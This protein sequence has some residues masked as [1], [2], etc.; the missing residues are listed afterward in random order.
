MRPSSEPITFVVLYNTATLNSLTPLYLFL[1]FITTSTQPVELLF[2]VILSHTNT[3]WSKRWRTNP[4]TAASFKI[5]R[6]TQECCLSDN[7]AGCHAIISRLGIGNK[8]MF[9]W[10]RRLRTRRVWWWGSGQWSWSSSS[11]K[12]ASAPGWKSRGVAA[13]PLMFEDLG[14]LFLAD[15]RA[16]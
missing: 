2:V 13:F 3:E 4:I 1:R 7:S 5:I 9:V 11:W 12:S 16:Y 14:R 8:W 15:F 10:D 6:P